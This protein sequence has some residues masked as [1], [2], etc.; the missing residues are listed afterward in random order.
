MAQVD[1]HLHT[2][3]SDGR[4][5]PAKLVALVANR[6][7]RVVAITDHDSTEGLAEALEAA[8]TFPNLTIIPGIELSS[9]I[10]GKEVHIL[11]Y[12]IRYSDESFQQTLRQFRVDRLER[13]RK[14]VDNLS[15]MGLPV[16]WE[17]VL[18]LAGGAVGRPHIAQAMVE[19]G[20]VSLPQ[21]AFA[22]YIGRNGPAYAERPKL[23]PGDAV[24]MIRRVDGLAVLAHPL[25]VGELSDLDT[26]IPDLRAA[27]LAGMEVHYG[28][29]TPSQVETLAAI[30]D[31]EGLVPCGGSD[32]HALGTPGEVEPGQVGPPLES[33][34]RLFAM[35]GT[36]V[37][38]R[39]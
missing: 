35:A 16:D 20:Y 34:D 1:L 10:P 39:L 30:A 11:G 31:R 9:D 26:I 36:R 15:N 12:F 21:D 14:M 4:L 37:D 6:G 33:A 8:G 29:Y 2:T 27:G 23:T 19:K 17:R 13:A 24:R 7:L 18:E 38:L 3:A 22:K 25:E 32:Y 5:T 28:S